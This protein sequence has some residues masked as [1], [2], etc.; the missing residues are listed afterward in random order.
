M[1]RTNIEPGKLEVTTLTDSPGPCE[2]LGY[3][4]KHTTCQDM[5]IQR[6]DYRLVQDADDLVPLLKLKLEAVLTDTNPPANLEG[7]LQDVLEH[8]ISYYQADKT[9]DLSARKAQVEQ[10]LKEAGIRP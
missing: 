6:F 3:Q 10:R 7:I 8:V 4:R 9:V 2:I 1:L 5:L